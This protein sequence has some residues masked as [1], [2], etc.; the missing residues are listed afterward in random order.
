MWASIC[1][2]CRYPSLRVAYIDEVENPNNDE[3]END[4]DKVSYYSVLV[5]AVPKSADASDQDQNFDQVQYSY[6]ERDY[7]IFYEM[8]SFFS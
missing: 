2:W 7:T 4:I 1:S 8:I 5:K 3:S 6:L